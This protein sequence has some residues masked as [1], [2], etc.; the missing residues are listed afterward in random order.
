MSNT[1][2]HRAFFFNALGEVF[3]GIVQYAEV[4][5]LDVTCQRLEGY[6]GS[7]LEKLGAFVRDYLDGDCFGGYNEFL[8]LYGHTNPTELICESPYGFLII[9]FNFLNF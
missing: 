3:A 7:S 4:G 9:V 8:E 5:E 6:E 2:P 1:E